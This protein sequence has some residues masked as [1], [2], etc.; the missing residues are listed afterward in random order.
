M[1][2]AAFLYSWVLT[3]EQGLNGVSL[4]DQE[5]KLLN[6]YKLQGL[7]PGHIIRDEG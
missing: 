4:K 2:Y 5:E 7:E 6:Y 1:K 3:E